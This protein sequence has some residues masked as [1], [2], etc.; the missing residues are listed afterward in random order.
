MVAAAVVILLHQ[1]QLKYKDSNF[2]TPIGKSK[3]GKR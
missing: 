3:I 1:Q 2:C